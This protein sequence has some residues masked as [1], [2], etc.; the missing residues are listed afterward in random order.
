MLL[1]KKFETARKNI[2]LDSVVS[3]ILRHQGALTVGQLSK[4][5]FVCSRQ[6]ER[7]YAEREYF[8]LCIYFNH[9]QNINEFTRTLYEEDQDLFQWFE[10]QFPERL[11]KCPN[12]RRVY[13]GSEPRRICGLSNRAEIVSPDDQDLDRAFYILRK[14]RNIDL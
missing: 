6:M 10:K 11:C 12:N 13:L 14:F 3:D 2:V 8:M 4:E 7:L 5:N 9:F 1:L